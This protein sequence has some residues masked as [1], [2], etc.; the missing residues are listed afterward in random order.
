M[1]RPRG[2][3]EAGKGG[4]KVIRKLITAAVM[5]ACAALPASA[6]T[7]VNFMYTAVNALVPVFVAKDEGFFASHGIDLDLTLTTNG[8]LISAAIIADTAQLGAPTP[9]VLLQANE[10]GLDLVAVAGTIV[11]PTT[12]AGGVLAASDSSIQGPRDLV[13]KR[14]GVPGLGGIIDVLSRKWVQAAGID[15]HKVNWIE[16]GFPQQADALKGHL[17]DGVASVDPFYSRVLAEKVGRPIGNYAD[18]IP[19]GTSPLPLVTTRSW[20]TQHAEAVGALKTALDEAVTYIADP[21]HA[22]SVRA[23]IAKYT[24]LPA[25]AVAAQAM[26]NNFQVH[27]TPESLR[28]WIEVS[29]EQG[30][31]KGNPDPRSLIY[32]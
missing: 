31:I 11:Y 1:V 23:S 16:I 2:Q 27:I 29:R 25:A 24:K 4:L 8:S 22:E 12:S 30:L 18:V 9:T 3:R 5:V 14:V 21:A 32:P 7:K 13:G 15:Y 28:F 17:V 20:A 10:Q 26:P 19:S 6:A